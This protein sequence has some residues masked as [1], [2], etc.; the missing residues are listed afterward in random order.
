M[1]DLRPSLLT[2]GY[3]HPGYGF[4][5]V[6]GHLHPAFARHCALQHCDLA[7]PTLSTM[8]G[9]GPVA[10]GFRQV[11]PVLLWRRVLAV[12]PDAVLLMADLD[13]VAAVAAARP[14][15]ATPRLAAYL[16]IDDPPAPVPALAG[17]GRLDAIAVF[18]EFA[19]RS[20]VEMLGLLGV[21]A[22]PIA[23]IPHGRDPVAFHPLDL[24]DRRSRSLARD[25]LFG[26]GS[27][28]ADSFLVLNANRNQPRKRIDLTLQ[29]F[30]RFVDLVPG[31]DARLYLHMGLQDH[32]IRILA[33]ADRLGIE[34]RLLFTRFDKA[35]PVVS[36]EQLNLVYNACDIGLNTAEAEGWGLVAFEHAAARRAQLV[37]DHTGCGEAWRGHAGLI[38]ATVG[39]DPAGRR[40]FEISVDRAA[41][42]I[43]D[44]HRDP[45]L[46][47]RCAARAY[48]HAVVD[49]PAWEE[50]AG[51]LLA[52]IGVPM[53]AAG[54]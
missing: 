47:A 54:P 17:L 7:A 10:G 46:R 8:P 45:D 15:G 9:A 21:P 19:R 27:A 48:R 33:E 23:V 53:A 25:R 35:H 31:A 2:I 4:G 16:P 12:R 20:V 1:T 41:L 29:V 52:A 6:L 49:T 28:V 43:A 22:P 24:D 32:G 18:T 51:R 3:A 44:L 38:P 30:R 37:P 14:A 42:M 50:V 39:T 13:I 36:D 26:L 11:D 5:R 34:N 40:V